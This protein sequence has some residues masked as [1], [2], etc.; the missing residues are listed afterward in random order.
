MEVLIK[1]NKTHLN[2]TTWYRI[3]GASC[4]KEYT[5]NF[6]TVCIFMRVTPHEQVVPGM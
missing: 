3:L 1:I 4:G 5:L 2:L 6:G